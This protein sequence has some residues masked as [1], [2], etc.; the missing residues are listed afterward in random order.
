[1]DPTGTGYSNFAGPD[2]PKDVLIV[3]GTS[4]LLNETSQPAIVDDGIYNHHTTFMDASKRVLN[5]LSC[6]GKPVPEVPMAFFLGSGSD[7]TI[8]TYNGPNNNVKSG[9]YVGKN[10]IVLVG[11]DG[12]NYHNR[13]RTLYMVNEIEY[14]P[15]MPKGYTHAQSHVIPMGL[16][17]GFSN[18]LA[19]WNIHPPAGQKKFVLEGK[20]DIEVTKDGHLVATCIEPLILPRL[21][22]LTSTDGHLHGGG[23]KIVFTVNGKDACESKI[24]YGGPGHEQVQPNGEIWKTIATNV[25]CED[26]IRVHKD[27]K[28]QLHAYFD[29]NEHPA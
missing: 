14:F 1:M 28:V 20:N 16:C 18:V 29:F 17:N 19:N 7:D 8:N 15:G 22:R 9:L 11:M 21:P 3:D 25:G 5:W 2:F 26:P 13:E 24:V 12:V 10:D 4:G 27:D 6:N 23:L